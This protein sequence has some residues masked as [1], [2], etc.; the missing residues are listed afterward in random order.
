MM[1][2]A[3][4]TPKIYDVK[5]THKALMMPK[6]QASSRA[7]ARTLLNDI[8]VNGIEHFGILLTDDDWAVQFPNNPRPDYPAYPVMHAANASQALIS[9][10]KE[11]KE[12]A[13]MV[14]KAVTQLKAGMLGA[15]DSVDLGSLFHN[16]TGHANVTC[17]EI[18]DYMMKAH[19]RI[20]PADVDYA[21]E[22]TCLIFDPS[23]WGITNWLADKTQGHDFLE[24]IEEETS[25]PD[26]YR[27]LVVSC[28][29]SPALREIIKK[30]LSDSESC[31]RRSRLNCNRPLG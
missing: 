12:L 15:L 25:D 26:K 18:M 2:I 4:T 22:Q 27:N 8:Y 5:G 7:A 13:R 20:T 17:A 24:S 11:E 10:Y 31:L 19:G 6:F 9:I 21:K 23:V 28:K 30:Y 1:E 29:N 16:E 3:T 14:S